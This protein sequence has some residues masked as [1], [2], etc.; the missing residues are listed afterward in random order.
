MVVGVT[1]IRPCLF[2]FLAKNTYN[3]TR[4]GKILSKTI[5]SENVT[6]YYDSP[7]DVRIIFISY[8]KENLTGMHL[9]KG[10]ESM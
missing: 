9:V 10:V 8:P 6:K 5:L 7:M 4:I 1:N 3:R 2:S